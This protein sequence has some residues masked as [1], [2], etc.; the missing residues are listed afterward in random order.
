MFK[1]YYTRSFFLVLIF[2]HLFRELNLMFVAWKKKQQK[3]KT[4]W[5]GNKLELF[6]VLFLRCFNISKLT[7]EEI[8]KMMEIHQSKK[9]VIIF[10]QIIYMRARHQPTSQPSVW[11]SSRLTQSN[12]TEQ[13]EGKYVPINHFY[14]L[15]RLLLFLQTHS[16]IWFLLER[17]VVPIGRRENNANKSS[18]Q[19]EFGQDY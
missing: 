19:N 3:R 18:I 2:F 7:Y 4:E 13:E 10:C 16:N 14:F 8:K 9:N 17:V 12:T 5:K 15:L 11:V 1:S 6:R